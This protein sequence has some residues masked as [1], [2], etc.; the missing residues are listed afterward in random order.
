MKDLSPEE[1]QVL[2]N[3]SSQIQ[4]ILSMGQ[5]GAPAPAG[6][7]A[8]GGVAQTVTRGDPAS[9]KGVSTGSWVGPLHKPGSPAPSKV[10]GGEEEPDGDEGRLGQGA[11]SNHAPSRTEKAIIVGDPDASTASSPADERLE[12]LPEWDEENLDQVVKGILRMALGK[13]VAKSRPQNPLVTALAG[14]TKAME[15]IARTQAEHATVLND[16]LEGLGVA[17]QLE[18]AQP[19]AR[20]Q[21]IQTM[22]QDNAFVVK[23]FVNALLSV[24][25]GAGSKDSS[26]VGADGAGLSPAEMVRKSAA[27]LVV[28]LKQVAGDLWEPQLGKD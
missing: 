19:P 2:S 5:A 17:K 28:G 23:E 13:G 26:S 12:D 10:E 14:I 27:E 22:P 7:G 1:M 11:P 18:E 8:P 20:R 24:T 3:M 15:T 6:A 16:V 25:K 4:Q 9:D 21:A